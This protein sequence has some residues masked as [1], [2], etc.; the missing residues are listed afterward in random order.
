[1]RLAD[2]LNKSTY[3]AFK[4]H[5]SSAHVDFKQETLL[6]SQLGTGSVQQGRKLNPLFLLLLNSGFLNKCVSVFK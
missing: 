4:L 3:N 6:K 2:A 5:I 1:M